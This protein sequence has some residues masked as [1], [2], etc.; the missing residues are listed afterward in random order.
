M[1][2]PELPKPALPHSRLVTKDGVFG[3]LY[4]EQQMEA[5][6]KACAVQALV[7]VTQASRL[8]ETR[9]RWQLLHDVL[10]AQET[11]TRADQEPL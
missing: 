3:K 8:L 9:K 6:G 2:L 11:H 4:T 5:Y 10:Y 1:K 7:R